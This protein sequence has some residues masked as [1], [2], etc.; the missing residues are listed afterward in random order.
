MGLLALKAELL[1]G[2]P[3]TGAYDADAQVA[4]DQLNLANRSNLRAAS[5]EEFREWAS[6]NGRGIKMQNAIAGGTSEAV[7]NAA[8]ILDKIIGSDSGSLD[9]GNATHVAMVN[10]LVDDGVWDA[11][12]RAAL[13][14]KAT[15]SISRGAELGLGFVK[16]GHVEMAR[17]M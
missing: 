5:V 10:A 11:A 8:Y 13:I 3:D 2:H 9:P 4:A 12:D 16:V 17:A 14:A 1:A 15:D 6:E 7:K